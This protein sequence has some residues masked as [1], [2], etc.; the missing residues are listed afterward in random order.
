MLMTKAITLKT[1]GF[2]GA[3]SGARTV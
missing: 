3:A 2:G 1:T